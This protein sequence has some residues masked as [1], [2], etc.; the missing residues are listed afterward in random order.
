MASKI[1]LFNPDPGIQRDGTMFSSNRW[2]DGQWMRFYRGKPRTMEGYR[3]LITV[4]N[5][6]RGTIIL[7]D[8]PNFNVYIADS[9]SIKYFSIDQTGNVITPPN[10]LIDRTPTLFQS[11]MNNDWAFDIMYDV[12]SNSSTLLSYAGQNLASIDNPV[13]TPI[14]YGDALATT[15]L[16]P[17]GL[18][19][20]GGIIVLHPYLFILKNDGNVEWTLANDPTTVLNDARITA[21]KLVYGARTRGGNTS[22]AGLIWSL[23]SLI[24][25]TNVGPTP[26]DFNFDT[27][28]DEISILSNKSV[29]EYNGKYFWAGLDTFY[30]Y[31]GVVN[32]LPNNI[33]LAFFFQNLNYSQRQKVWATKVSEWG[34]IW[35]H[36]PKGNSIECNHAVI[37]NIRENAWYDTAISRSCG[38]F[39]Q[40]FQFPIWCDNTQSGGT[41]PVWQHEYGNNKNVN[42][43]ITA[44]NK[45][46]EGPDL[47]FCAFSPAGSFTGLDRQVKLDRVEPDFLGFPDINGNLKTGDITLVAN[48]R[49]YAQSV[50]TPSDTFTFDNTDGKIDIRYQARLMTLKFTSN[51]VDGFFEM[52]QLL[53]NL[54]VGDGRQ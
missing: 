12:N 10:V 5:V 40:K 30:V 36:F 43:V 27:I 23:D 34:E 2:S 38:D 4:P 16:V 52:G 26:S 49:N 39:D 21:S 8:S 17:T 44:I 3:Q 7:S 25:V 22:P 9:G 33:S 41:Y 6:P 31:N 45:Y 35:W 47:S 24:R 20:S 48:G 32:E 53:L 28:S 1:F 29:I 13:E 18:S 50:P 14:Y 54:I 42:G 11:N 51:V 19:T 15:P 37:Y 46:I